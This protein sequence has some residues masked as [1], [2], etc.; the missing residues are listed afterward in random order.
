MNQR[1]RLV[2]LLAEA[3]KEN[4]EHRLLPLLYSDKIKAIA[5]HLL[6]NGVIVPPCKVGDELYVVKRMSDKRCWQGYARPKRWSAG[7]CSCGA[8]A[9]WP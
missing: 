9:S 5:D 1:D 7:R 6:A 8:R 4:G 2:E 3:E